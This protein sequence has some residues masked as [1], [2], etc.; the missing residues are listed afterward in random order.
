MDEKISPK[1]NPFIEWLKGWATKILLFTVA[2]LLLMLTAFIFDSLGLIEP[3]T[4]GGD[5][6]DLIWQIFW[7]IAGIVGSVSMAIFIFIS[8]REIFR[9]R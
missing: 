7:A 9:K 8:L 5:P 2:M 6:V 1:K 4:Y 3:E